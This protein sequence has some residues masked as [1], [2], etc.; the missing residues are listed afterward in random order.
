MR[1]FRANEVV[2]T[3]DD[4]TRVARCTHQDAQIVCSECRVEFADVLVA[5]GGS[6]LLLINSGD[7]EPIRRYVAVIEAAGDEIAIREAMET[8]QNWLA[9]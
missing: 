2:L 8:V 9:A 6:H 7:R 4:L 3:A 5:V 1:F